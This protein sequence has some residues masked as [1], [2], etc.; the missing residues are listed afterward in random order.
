MT[1]EI[2]RKQLVLMLVIVV[3]LVATL[4]VSMMGVGGL[5]ELAEIFIPKLN[6]HCVSSV[7][8]I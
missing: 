5:I 6:G 2:G 4:M 3:L 7:C 8:S 1:F